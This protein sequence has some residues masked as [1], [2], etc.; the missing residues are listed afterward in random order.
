MNS[1]VSFPTVMNGRVQ[2]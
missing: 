2:I 1:F